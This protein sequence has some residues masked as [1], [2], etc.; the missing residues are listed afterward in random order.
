V[1]I[2]AGETGSGKTTQLPKIC[3]QLGRGN[4][5]LIGHTQPRRLAA[6]TVAQR[7]ADE[8][9]GELGGLVGYQ[10]RFTE[11]ISPG[12]RVKLMTDGILLA[13][14]KRDRELRKYDT[15]II[16]EAHERSLN[17]DFLLGYLKRLL[18]RRPDLKLIITSATIDVESFSRHFDDAPIVEVSGRMFPVATHYL[19]PQQEDADLNDRILSAVEEIRGR[20]YGAPGDILVFLSGERDI[21]ELARLLR[22][23][24]LPDLEVLP[25]YA[26]L[27]QAEQRRVF[28]TGKRRGQRIVLATNVAET[29]LTVPG[30]RYVIDPGYARI[31]RYS[32]RTQVQRLPIEAISQASANQR[33]GRCGRVA[34]GVCLRLYSEQDFNSRPEFT[35][36]EIRRTNLAAVVLQMLRMKMGAVEE[37]PFLN[38]PDQ[39]LVRDG[40]KQLLELG[41]VTEHKRL[42]GIG[43]RMADFPV[44]PRFARML[45]AA[46]SAGCLREILIITSGMSVQDPR[47]RPADKRQASDEKH[48]RFWHE[49]SDFLAWV[50]V[51]DYYE[52]QRQ[53]LSQNRLRKLCQREYLSY[54]RMREWRDI[55]FQLTLACR[56]A[57][58]HQNREAAS[59]ESVHRVLLSGLLGNLGQWL[60]GYEYQGSRNR[61]LQI[62]PGSSQFKKKP[63]WLLAGEI[64]E[65]SKVYAR[66]VAAV[67]PLWALDINPALLK[68]HYYEPHWQARQGRVMALQ[69]ISLYGLVLVD[70]Q[71]VHYGPVDSAQARE[72]LISAALVEGRTRAPPAFL[73]HNLA[74][75]KALEQ[76]ESRLR[77]RDIVVDEQV[78][79][80][81]Y[82]E[83][84]PQDITTMARLKNWLRR[85]PAADQALRMSRQQL[86]L[87][88]LDES[89]GE[90]F[91]DSLSWQDMELPLSYH[92]EPGTVSDGVSVT[93]PV[94]LLNRV[95]RYRFQWLVP[96]LLREKCIQLVKGLPKPVRKHL[97]P[98]PD[99]VDRALV[100]MKPVDR[101]LTE[102]LGERLQQVSGVKISPE[103]WHLRPLDSYYRMNFRVVDT[104]GKLIEQGRDLPGL[105]ESL[106]E[107][108]RAELQAGRD[109][110]P[111]QQGLTRWSMA[112]VPQ[113]WR[114]R[115]A[116]VEVES[117]PALVDEGDS[118][119]VMLLDYPG[120]ARLAH[121][122]GLIRLMRLQCAEQ[123]RYLRKQMLRGNEASLVLAGAGFERP[124]LVEDLV[125][126][127]FAQALLSGRD[128]PRDK[129]AFDAALKQGRGQLV[130]CANEYESV[131]LN[132][133]K[134]LAE[135]RRCLADLAAGDQYLRDD[136]EIQLA[137]LFKAGFLRDTDFE[138]VR[139]Y[140]RY[141][142]AILQR[143]QRFSGQQQK[144]RAQCET[145][146]GHAKPLLALLERDPGALQLNP[147]TNRYRWMLEEFR[148]SLYAQGLGTS[149]HVSAKRLQE[150][151]HKALDWDLENSR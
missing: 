6:R 124:P 138:W 139:Q 12:T 46:A 99:Y 68:H 59:Y 126:A 103:L 151:W 66:M 147:Q 81:F 108:T 69:R 17:I 116:G 125:D 114:Q 104:D 2:I 24:G 41:A 5:A 84:L 8:L 95:P 63:K 64:V 28:S 87:R 107:Q 106:R 105:L 18:P 150:Q 3:L 26:R 57:G 83:R 22:R 29:S 10:V 75:V 40:Y 128:L 121:R 78:Q 136:I 76:L 55:H 20:V 112:E 30:I 51:W 71:R 127:S 102:V 120:Q 72:I 13:E 36:A 118:V 89:L 7:I 79:L 135:V 38:P 32:Y 67:D 56:Q 21:R 98:V 94:G 70:K 143:L 60:E 146:R 109:D 129:A 23:R 77:R 62:F 54:M 43:R 142:R 117:Y 52:E 91:P 97:V 42:T 149:F 101:A 96:G 92:F 90:Q 49:K 85:E 73:R 134:P 39:R 1:V 50:N 80:D 122:G 34:A 115:Q 33:R 27:S 130:T 25:L 48:R 19:E 86:S 140:P 93:L 4:A 132:T 145:L 144:D 58:L 88:A 31:S 47:E 14:I 141:C 16:D 137:A 119:A 82:R 11:Q 15:L 74:Q 45:L 44:D 100:D 35:E 123:V 37:F 113:S 110:S 148:V 131:L 61:K 65:T 111:A 9:G 133:L 53:A